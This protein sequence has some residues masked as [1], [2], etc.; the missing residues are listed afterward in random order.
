MLKI[1]EATFPSIDFEGNNDSSSAA[2]DSAGDRLAGL[3]KAVQGSLSKDEVA[4]SELLSTLEALYTVSSLRNV[5]D[6]TLANGTQFCR[7][8]Q[9]IMSSTASNYDVNR[10]LCGIA[11][12]CSSVLLVVLNLHGSMLRDADFIIFTLI[13]ILY[14]IMMFASSYVEEEQHFWYWIGAGWIASLAWTRYG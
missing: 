13:A 7:E 12:A 11:L 8:A 14:S 3:W 9:D 2:S 10:L 6:R 1:V 4:E 5:H